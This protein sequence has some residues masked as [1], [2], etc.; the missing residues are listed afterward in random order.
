M[1]ISLSSGTMT[2]AMNTTRATS[3]MMPAVVGPPG[4]SEDDSGR[5]PRGR[6]GR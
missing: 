6:R 3:V 5:A 2:L 4:E 1:A